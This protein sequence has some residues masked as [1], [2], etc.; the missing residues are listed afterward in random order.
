MV[1]DRYARSYL[2]SDGPFELRWNKRDWCGVFLNRKKV[3]NCNGVFCERT[4]CAC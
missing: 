2:K 4:F 3:W 1:P